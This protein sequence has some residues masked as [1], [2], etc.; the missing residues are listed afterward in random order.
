MSGL[1]RKKAYKGEKYQFSKRLIHSFKI[2]R[3]S[4]PNPD[5]A[6]S[7]LFLSERK[8]GAGVS[9]KTEPE[10]EPELTSSEPEPE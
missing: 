10:P 5:P 6:S 8:V 3:V 4:E 9:L 1:S 2:F 7:G